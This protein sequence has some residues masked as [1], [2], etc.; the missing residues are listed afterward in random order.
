MLISTKP[1]L[2]TIPLDPWW[3]SSPT[4]S[5]TSWT[6]REVPVCLLPQHLWTFPRIC[7]YQAT[8]KALLFDTN[9]I[10]NWIIQFFKSHPNL[11][12]SCRAITFKIHVLKEIF[13]TIWWKS[14]PMTCAKGNLCRHLVQYHSNY[15][16]NR[17]CMSV[18][19]WCNTIPITCAKG[20]VCLSPFGAITFQLHVQQ[21]MFVTIWCNN[22]PITCANEIVVTIWCNNIPIICAKGYVCHHLV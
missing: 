21:E 11:L 7:Q 6:F 19:I 18:A 12:S 15:M 4:L 1:I 10:F 22:I 9:F 2:V 8:R 14:I 17:K 13:V 16:C 5:M 3:L 20:N